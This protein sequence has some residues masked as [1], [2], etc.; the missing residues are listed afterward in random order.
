MDGSTVLITG[1]NA[2]VGLETARGVAHRGARVLLAARDAAKGEAA[3]A[4][5]R[6][7]VPG[8]AVEVVDL[9][10]AS[11]ASIHRSRRRWGADP[12]GSTCWSTTRG[13]SRPGGC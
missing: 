11:F 7:S 13:W 2:G 4:N 10:L 5:V 9:D 1:A 8:A 3:A 6:A 12:T